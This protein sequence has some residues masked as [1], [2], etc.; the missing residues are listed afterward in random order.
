MKTVA[1]IVRHRDGIWCI[2]ARLVLL[3]WILRFTR[4]NALRVDDDDG[5]KN[6]QGAKGGSERM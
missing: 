3:I 5:K 1:T 2:T 6:G 4:A